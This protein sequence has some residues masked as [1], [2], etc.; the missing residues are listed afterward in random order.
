MI[1]LKIY[2]DPMNNNY[3]SK[4][5]HNLKKIMDFNSEFPVFMQST[6]ITRKIDWV[7]GTSKRKKK[8]DEN[9]SS[10]K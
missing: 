8:F 1:F 4:K 5:N 6:H 10:L 3:D 7:F 9:E 2:I